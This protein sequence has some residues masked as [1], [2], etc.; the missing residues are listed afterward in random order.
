MIVHCDSIFTPLKHSDSLPLIT[1]AYYICAHICLEMYQGCS[2]CAILY[3]NVCAIT[4]TNNEAFNEL[5]SDH[6]QTEGTDFLFQ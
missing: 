2:I 4:I 3:L 6:L 5:F 1:A